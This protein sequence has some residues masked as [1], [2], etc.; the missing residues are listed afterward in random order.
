MTERLS[1]EDIKARQA[2]SDPRSKSQRDAAEPR[3]RCA[4][5]SHNLSMT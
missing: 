5:I 4:S 3:R 2:Q 1:W